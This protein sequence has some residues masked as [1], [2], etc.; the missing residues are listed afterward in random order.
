MAEKLQ[1]MMG[2][3]GG[4][5]ADQMKAIQA[6]MGGKGGD[7]A[8]QLKAMMGDKSKIAESLKGM[9]KDGKL[10]EAM[11]GMG[12]H[13]KDAMQDENFHHVMKHTAKQMH[14]YQKH[15]ARAIS[16]DG[17]ADDAAAAQNLGMGGMGALGDHFKELLEHEDMKEVV[18]SFKSQLK[19]VMADGE[20]KDLA[21]SF[22]HHM[23]QAKIDD[24]KG[25]LAS[26]LTS[27]RPK[28]EM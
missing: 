12:K 15:A 8:E 13:I 4:N 18:D 21:D 24:Q 20:M 11:K 17:Q 22:G 10:Q 27:A 7:M 5:M 1:A 16:A 2:G 14:H 9:M 25:S 28:T 19:E 6:M 3:K 23:K 26:L